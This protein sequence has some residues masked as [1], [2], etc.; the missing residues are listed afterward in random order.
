[1]AFTPYQPPSASGRFRQAPNV[2]DNRREDDE[3]LLHLC[4]LPGRV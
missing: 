2:I 4:S 3:M 1:M